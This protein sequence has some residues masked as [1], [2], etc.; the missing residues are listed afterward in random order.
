MTINADVQTPAEVAVHRL[1]RI[2]TRLS[3]REPC[4]RSRLAI[5]RLTD[6][7]FPRPGGSAIE[8]SFAE[9]TPS[10]LRCDLARGH[11]HSDFGDR[12][13]HALRIADVPAAKWS[14]W[15]PHFASDRFGAF[16]SAVIPNDGEAVE[17]KAFVEV[18]RD[19][20]VLGAIKG[21]TSVYASLL[22]AIP[23]LTPHLVALGREGFG[24]YPRLHFECAG[25]IELTSLVHWAI[26]H[27]LGRQALAAVHV[28]RR[29]TGGSLV[30]PEAAGVM[31]ALR[32]VNGTHAEFE[33][34]LSS[35]VLT[36]HPLDAIRAV[37]IERPRSELAFRSWC[38]SVEQPIEPTVVSVRISTELAGP[39]ISVSTALAS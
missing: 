22:D 8:V 15:Q 18:A 33:L 3:G 26:R 29:L 35:S 23:G 4:A 13:D 9:S 20:R 12:H 34:E 6:D 21:D 27:G 16:V 24:D 30:L 11:S 5:E 32:A 36:H 37:L 10:A 2:L 19:R 14:R 38:S 31:C 25:G 39:R 1:C 7:A 28:A 17:Y